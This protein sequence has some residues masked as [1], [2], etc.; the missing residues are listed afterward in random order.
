MNKKIIFSSMVLAFI[1]SGCLATNPNPTNDIDKKVNKVDKSAKKAKKVVKNIK[2]EVKSKKDKISKPE[3]SKLQDVV[4]EN[5]ENEVDITDD[6][7]TINKPQL[8]ESVD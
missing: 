7:T 5:I 8:I 6:G 4:I 1:F 2:D 3:E